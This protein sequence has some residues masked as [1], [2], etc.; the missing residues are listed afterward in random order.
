MRPFDVFGK[1][2]PRTRADTKKKKQD[3]KNN[4]GIFMLDDDE[5]WK[6]CKTDY[7]RFDRHPDV[8]MCVKKIADLI[9]SM[10]IFFM[11]N[12][13]LGD[14]RVKNSFSRILDIEP[15]RYMTRRT[16]MYKAAEEMLLTGNSVLLPKYTTNHSNN[17][18]VEELL[19]ELK[20]VSADSVSYKPLDDGGYTASIKGVPFTDDEIVHFVHNPSPDEPWRGEGLKVYL[21]DILANLAD[22]QKIKGDYYKKHY[23][24]NIVFTFN[25]DSAEF[26]DGEEG[27]QKIYEKWIKV[28]PGE[29]YIIPAHIA[30]FK[31]FPPLSLKDIAINENVELDKK[32]IAKLFGIPLFMIG[33]APFN[34]VEYNNFI[35]TTITPIVKG[36]EQELTRK[37]VWSE[38]FYIKFNLESL[39]SFDLEQRISMMYTG[40]KLG[41]YNANEIRIQAGYEPVDKPEMNEYSILENFIPTDK[42]GEQKKLNGG[43]GDNA[44]GN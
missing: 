10:T 4:T 11:Q 21:K 34:K 7:I 35:D 2:R 37:L 19:E 38:S 3:D 29:P 9:S 43:D 20:P 28:K 30:D 33:L 5:F 36:M 32:A 24:P 27:K 41:V 18:A 31:H 13:E 1:V 15:N 39:K 23:K 22:A 42:I 44:D 14:I 16:L 26:A 17:F 6:S 12:T 25:A 8:K 40:K